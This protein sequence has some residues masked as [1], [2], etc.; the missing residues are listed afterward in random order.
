MT[1]PVVAPPLERGSRSCS[2]SC[3]SFSSAFVRVASSIHDE[4]RRGRSSSTSRCRPPSA[5]GLRL[6]SSP[7]V[8]LHEGLRERLAHH[9]GRRSVRSASIAAG[10]SWCRS[11]PAGTGTTRRRTSATATAT[12]TRARCQRRYVLQSPIGTFLL[13]ASNFL[14]KSGWATLIAV[15]SGKP[16]LA[17]VA[18]PRRRR[19][20]AS[21]ARRGHAVVDLLRV[22]ELDARHRR[23]GELALD[24]QH[25]LRV[26][27]RPASASRRGARTCARRASRRRRGCPW[28]ARRPG[29]SSRA[30]A[31]PGRP[32]RRRRSSCA[33]S[34]KS[35][36]LSKSNAA[37]TPIECRCATPSTSVFASRTASMRSSS[38]FRSSAP[39]FSIPSSS[40]H[41]AQSR[42]AA[43]RRRRLGCRP[44]ASR[45][46]MARSAFSF[47]CVDDAEAAHPAGFVV[48]DGR[49]LH[50]AA[51]CKL[52]EVVA[53]RRRAIE[54]RLVGSL[55]I[56]VGRPSVRAAGAA[57]RRP[58]AAAHAAQAAGCAPQA[59]ASAH[60]RQT[61]TRPMT[62]QACEAHAC[63]IA[64]NA[65]PVTP[66]VRDVRARVRTAGGPRVDWHRAR[67]A[68]P[69]SRRRAP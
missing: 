39:R 31:A 3:A 28:C 19:E 34:L 46:R 18:V 41:D 14:T 23:A 5:R 38:G 64:Q 59:N 58:V 48:R 4:R 12:S 17:E 6:P 53:G 61:P 57:R 67:K 47:S 25:G 40:M 21:S 56:W 35:T 16:R 29:S 22:A 65:T 52:V 8:L 66:F 15:M 30:R 20:R 55:E 49:S 1:R 68:V 62:G 24:L 7:K 44:A 42:R 36:S 43:C 32:A 45:S 10:A 33:A 51:A 13:I 60:G 69:C 2:G 63:P 11:G 9:L 50:P 26:G 37:P 27:G 54:R